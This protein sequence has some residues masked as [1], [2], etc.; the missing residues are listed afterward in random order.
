MGG[1]SG[2]IEQ[3]SRLSPE[4][5]EVFTKLLGDFDPAALTEMFQTSVGDPAR[6]QFRRQTIPGIQ[7]RFIGAGAGRSG[8][9]MRAATGAGADL[10]SGL[11]GQLA[12]LL[13]QAQENTLNRQANLATSNVMETFQRPSESSPIMDLLIPIAGGLATGAGGPLAGGAVSMLSTK[14]NKGETPTG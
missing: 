10:E 1:T 12:Q 4:Q 14:M 7:E 8:A 5:Q 2:G 13:T 6:T 3:V 9:A 11:S